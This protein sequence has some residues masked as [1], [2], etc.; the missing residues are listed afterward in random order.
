MSDGPHRSLPMRKAWKDL[1]KCA[2]QRTY[3]P[4]QVREAALHALS[5][6]WKKEVPAALIVALKKVF[7]RHENSLGFQKILI[8]QLEAARRL[9]AGRV[10][11]VNII[12]WCIELVH[13]GRTDLNTLYDAVR[14]S[15][16]DRAFA[17][18]R[19]VEEHYLREA[20]LKRAVGVKARIEEAISGLSEKMLGEDL[21]DSQHS[22]GRTVKKRKDIDDGVPL[23]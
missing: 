14:S 22:T 18:A 17:G 19:Q 2:D 11:G 1:A 8:E 15:I 6:D 13:G 7:L 21:L 20:T 23:Q 12:D 9:A 10:L 5:S 16:Q 3:E 4:E